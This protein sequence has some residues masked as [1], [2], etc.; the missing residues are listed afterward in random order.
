[1]VGWIVCAGFTMRLRI[2]FSL[3][4]VGLCLQAS[5]W[6]CGFLY[7]FEFMVGWIVCAGFTMRLRIS[8]TTCPPSQRKRAWEMKW[9]AASK[10]SF[11]NSGPRHR[12]VCPPVCWYV[13]IPII[14]AHYSVHLSWQVQIPFIHAHYSLSTCLDKSRFLSSMLTTVCPPAFTG[15]DSRCLHMSTSPSSMLTI[16]CWY[17]QI[18]IIHAW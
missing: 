7:F 12:S 10:G 13:Q 16:V 3:W 8:L 2:F 4:L 15:P 11:K 1:M 14:H 18:P 17:V 6:N 5:P 9:S